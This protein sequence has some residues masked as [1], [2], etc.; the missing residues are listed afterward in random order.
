MGYIT[1][2]RDDR[3]K[4]VMELIAKEDRE[5]LFPVG[6]L[7]KDTEGLLLFTDDG[8]F[9][10]DVLSP[11]TRVEKTYMFW[12][13]GDLTDEKIERLKS[14]VIITEAGREILTAPAAVE[15]LFTKPMREIAHLLGEDESKLRNTRRGD[16]PVTSCIIKI[17]EGRKHQVKK[18]VKAVGMYVVYLERLAIGAL[19]LDRS[20]KRGEY[21]SLTEAELCLLNQ[22]KK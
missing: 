22:Q 12:A 15:P 16:I 3:H 4:T 2:C 1:A 18:M 9:C 20:L 17:T 14:G 5:G 19:T 7:D 21:R 11:T 8:K 13:R 10:F 6:R